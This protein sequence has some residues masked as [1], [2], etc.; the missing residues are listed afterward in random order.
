MA[1][2]MTNK[3]K[4][5]R[6]VIKK[7][8]QADGV[9]PPDKPR[10]NRRKFIQEAR[11]EYNAFAKEC[12][13]SDLYLHR[14]VSVLLGMVKRNSPTPEAVGEAK[15]LKLAVRLREFDQM[16]KA[17]WDTEYRISEQYDYIKDI[18]EA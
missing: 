14:A 2:G 8:L 3:E 13:V 16:V 9:L 1:K 6:A 17:R 7:Q 10:L 18:L 15:A 11:E 5:E 4:K 12:M